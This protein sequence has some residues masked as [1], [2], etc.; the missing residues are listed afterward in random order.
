MNSDTS[1]T[2]TVPAQSAG[3][4]NVIVTTPYGTSQTTFANQFTYAPAPVVDSLS[5]DS[6]ITGGDTITISGSGFTGATGVSFGGVAAT[7]YTVSSDSSITAV[8]PAQPAGTIVG[9]TVTTPGGVSTTPSGEDLTYGEATVVG[10]LGQSSGPTDG[11]YTI[12][13]SGSG[14]T[15]Q[16]PFPSAVSPQYRTP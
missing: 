5:Q 7:S 14:F 10:G 9:V 1:K 12:T 6:G 11:G 15:A 8:V 3:N 4:V 13:V 2:A 16:P